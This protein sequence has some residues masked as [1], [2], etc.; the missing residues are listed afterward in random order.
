MMA[1]DELKLD[2]IDR[3]RSLQDENKRL[4]ERAEQAESAL[5]SIAAHADEARQQAESGYMPALAAFLCGVAIE[6]LD[7][8]PAGEESPP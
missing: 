4:R 6:A 3:L 7:A 2:W 5:R 1:T 8:A